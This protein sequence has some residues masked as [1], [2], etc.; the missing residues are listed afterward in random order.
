MIIDFLGTRVFDT[1]GLQAIDLLAEKYKRLGKNLQLRHLSP[2][3]KALLDKAGDLMT[4]NVIEDPKY[5]VA[6][7]YGARFDGEKPKSWGGISKPLG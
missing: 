6:V 1:S 4:V 5:G 2:D 3:C 7:D